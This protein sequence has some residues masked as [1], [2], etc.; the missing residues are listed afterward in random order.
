MTRKDDGPGVP[1]GIPRTL[2]GLVDRLGADSLDRLWI[3][4]PRIKGRRES[5]LVVVSRFFEDGDPTRRGLFTASYAAERT[6]KGLTVEW[7]LSEEGT[8]PP[9]RLPPVMEGVL[10][11][12]GEGDHEVREVALG[13]EV[14]RLEGL[15]DEWERALLD[16]ELWPVAVVEAATEESSGDVGASVEVPE[17]GA[18]LV[19]VPEVEDAP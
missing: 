13:G 10:R 8:A 17:G 7:S 5:G 4:A 11:R 12:S 18:Q 16:P 2:Q 14:E 19:E 1:E 9:D 6:G 3:F 15:F